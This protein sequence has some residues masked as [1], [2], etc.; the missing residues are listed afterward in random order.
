ME[1]ALS[2]DTSIIDKQDDAG[3]TP[4]MIASSAG[5]TE[6]VR[7]LLSFPGVQINQR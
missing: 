7:R 2:H 1:Q 4:L 5:R 6:I 3:W